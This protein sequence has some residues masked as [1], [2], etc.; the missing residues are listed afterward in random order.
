MQK[1]TRETLLDCAET[2]FATRGFYGT[3]LAAIAGELNLTKQALL[4]HFGS[5]EKIYG[6]VLA[7]I[8]DAYRQK[9]QAIAT[10]NSDPV[11]VL[12]TYLLQLSEDALT[13]NARTRLIMRELLDN[14]E[15]AQT[16]ENWYLATFLDTLIDMVKATPQ[17]ANISDV[18][19]LAFIYQ[20]LGALNYF[21]VSR[22]TLTGIFGK[23]RYQA[24]HK[25][26]SARL[27]K[28]IDAGLTTL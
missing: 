8:S 11:L 17:G 12:K 14:N 28:L 25:V 19:A 2:L 1:N 21:A 24:V 13:A 22:P 10:Q 9:Q 4:H 27:E 23:T 26:F 20:L 7:R 16:A 15:R 3:S 5:K 6:A 18:E